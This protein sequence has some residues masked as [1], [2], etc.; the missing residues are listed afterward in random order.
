[1]LPSP[2]VERVMKRVV[3]KYGE[4]SPDRQKIITE[5]VNRFLAERAVEGPEGA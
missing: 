4:L 2:L 5:E 3:E 1:V